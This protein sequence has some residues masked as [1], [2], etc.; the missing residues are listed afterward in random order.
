[1]NRSTQ[2]GEEKISKLLLN[3]SIPAIIGMLVSALYNVVDRIYIGNAKDIGAFGIAGITISMPIMIFMMALGML[4]GIGGG[5]LTAIRLGEGK[6]EEAENIMGNAVAGITILTI[7][8]ALIF[9]VLMKPILV[10]FGTSPEIMPYASTYLHIILIGSVFSSLGMCL[11]N[12]IRVDG[13]PKIAMATQILGAIINA[14]IVPVFIFVFHWG[15][16]GAAFATI[17]SQFISM[18]WTINYFISA[19]SH[20]KLRFKHLRLH[21]PLLL[22]IMSIGMPSFLMQVANMFV[23]ILL[24]ARLSQLGGDLAISGIGIVSSLQ[25]LLIMPILGI[26]QGA[27]PIIGFNYG[28]KKF[29]RVKETLKLAVLSA[30]AFSII[31]FA[32][33]EAFPKFFITLFNR[34]PELVAFGV[35]AIRIILLMLPIVGFQII[36][37]SYFQGIGKSGLATFLT[38][39][40]QV[41]ILI[42]AI[43]ILSSIF[44][45]YGVIFAIP[46]ADFV[47]GVL[48]AIFISIEMKKNLVI[49]DAGDGELV[50]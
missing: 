48:T 39:S 30:T 47:A 38:L 27:Q 7:S 19:K 2:L 43:M 36:C 16:A 32:L 34:T 20:L 41:I 5:A 21:T 8:F 4:F 10:L 40:R 1:M 49:S 42:P 9:T 12:F 11:N 33:I 6:R 24:N 17:I 26:N 23:N 46:L 29:A 37:S 14:L 35:D 45:I 25:M 28:A 15:I 3:F 18:A 31:G 44:G 22:K 50:A 13:N